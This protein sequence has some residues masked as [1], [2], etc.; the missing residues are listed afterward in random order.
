MKF[1]LINGLIQSV[2]AQ[3]KRAVQNVFTVAMEVKSV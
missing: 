2:D 3:R 1:N